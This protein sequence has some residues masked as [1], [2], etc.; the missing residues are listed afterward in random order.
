MWYHVWGMTLQWG[1]TIKVSI[2]LPVAPRH[3]LDMTE[4][5]LKATL[6]PNKQQHKTPNACFSWHG[7]VWA[8]GSVFSNTLTVSPYQKGSAWKLALT[9]LALSVLSF[10]YGANFTIAFYDYY[11]VFIYRELLSW[12]NLIFHEVISSNI[13]IYKQ[14]VEQDISSF[15]YT[16]SIT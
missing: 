12:I 7:D 10:V 13:Y 8:R 3:R 4:K 9:D 1:S 14:C 15:K 6:N 2:K 5:L 11:Y 16:S